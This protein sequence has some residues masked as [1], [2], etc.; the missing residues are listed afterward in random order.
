MSEDDAW[1]TR[2]S[3][4]REGGG[5]KDDGV[6]LQ[7]LG[8]PIV[9]RDSSPWE[10][11][12]EVNNPTAAIWNPL[13]P[14]KSILPMEN[15][16][17]IGTRDEPAYEAD[18]FLEYMPDVNKALAHT[19]ATLPFNG[20]RDDGSSIPIGRFTLREKLQNERDI[21]AY[22]G[23]KARRMTD[24]GDDEESNAGLRCR[25]IPVPT[26]EEL[27][28]FEK[29]HGTEFL[30][31][32][33]LGVSLYLKS[34]HAFLFLALF[35][36][37]A[38]LPQL[39]FYS[40]GN[41]VTQR[42]ITVLTDVVPHTMSLGHVPYN[43][44]PHWPNTGINRQDLFFLLS[45]IDSMSWL[46]WMVVVGIM[47]RRQQSETVIAD[48]IL[49]TA[50]DYTILVRKIPM[51]S[52]SHSVKQYFE[53][54]WPAEIYADWAYSEAR[55]TEGAFDRDD[56]RNFPVFTSG[57]NGQ[58]MQTCDRLFKYTERREVKKET[59]NGTVN[60]TFYKLVN[61]AGDSI[62]WIHDFNEENP[63]IPTIKDHAKTQ[64]ADVVVHMA[65]SK[66]IKALERRG[67]AFQQYDKIDGLLQY[68]KKKIADITAKHPVLSGADKSRPRK[69]S[70]SEEF[71]R[72]AIKVVKRCC[73]PDAQHTV[74]QKAALELETALNQYQQY[75]F[76]VEEMGEDIEI[77]DARVRDFE[78]RIL[79]EGDKFD[80]ERETLDVLPRMRSMSLEAGAGQ[81]E[82]LPGHSA[83]RQLLN[84]KKGHGS[85]A[86]DDCSNT[87]TPLRMKANCAFVTFNDPSDA[88][89]VLRD[90][91]KKKQKGIL[92]FQYTAERSP[93]PDDIIFENLEVG[94]AERR[95]R[96]RWNYLIITI[97]LIMT[98]VTTS[99]VRIFYY[100]QEANRLNN[101]DDA[102]GDW[103]Y[104]AQQGV[105]AWHRDRC[106]GS[107]LKER[108]R[109]AGIILL[110]NLFVSGM[111]LVLKFIIRLRVR[112]EKHAV[113][114]RLYL[115]LSLKLTRPNTT[116]AALAK[117]TVSKQAVSEMR[118]VFLAQYINTSVLVGFFGGSAFLDGEMMNPSWYSDNGTSLFVVTV[119]NA[120]ADEIEVSLR[121]LKKNFDKRFHRARTQQE[122]NEAYRYMKFNLAYQ[123]ASLLSMIFS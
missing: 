81:V 2:G 117:Q 32:F 62:G 38:S 60:A 115:N 76:M 93:E 102:K 29:Q 57:L 119:V 101:E 96:F 121:R 21:V 89:C 73:A 14:M 56:V 18:F 55:I 43:S 83:A 17:G 27:E 74:L 59:S 63:H 58:R 103:T 70:I 94:S 52:T 82:K 34:I 22:L 79:A 122:L 77:L 66:M 106:Y 120:V 105:R 20:E 88:E 113:R 80:D 9:D 92:P 45:L 71:F 64:V 37:L 24:A 54:D 50:S 85:A 53:R 49:T 107:Y 98:G 95:R 47:Q 99:L 25:R 12:P 97:L 33:G 109:V 68:T 42:G 44:Q 104:C 6:A 41:C 67:K 78:R 51:D 40:A 114:L 15:D 61:D 123:Y 28:D 69:P 75:E 35:M 5:S 112:T 87:P 19:K 7:R 116:L 111:N 1:G 86:H 23:M 72:K 100:L 84:D 11:G 110:C 16:G 91:E 36:F 3:G 31:E 118:L 48:I 4:R 30:R 8:D 39:G 13:V 46:I 108:M 26:K 10:H 65:C 90:V